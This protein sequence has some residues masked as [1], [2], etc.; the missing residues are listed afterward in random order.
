MHWDARRVSNRGKESGLAD[1]ELISLGIQHHHMAEAF[2]MV[3]LGHHDRP[4][5]DKLG[6][7]RPDQALTLL[8]I[9]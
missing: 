6:S 5:R 1:A 4:K 7:L 9:P 8:P 2:L 3:L